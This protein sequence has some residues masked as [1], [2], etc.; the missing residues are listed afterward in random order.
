MRQIVAWPGGEWIQ[1]W[2]AKIGQRTRGVS[3][4]D[5]DACDECGEDIIAACEAYEAESVAEAL[6]Q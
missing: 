1:D 2:Y 5:E 4:I 6:N 3:E